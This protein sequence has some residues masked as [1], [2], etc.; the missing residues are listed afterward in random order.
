MSSRVYKHSP[1][2]IFCFVSTTTILP[3]I[4]HNKILLLIY[5]LQ[6][7]STFCLC[8]VMFSLIFV[9]IPLF[10]FSTGISY[11]LALSPF[12]TMY[13]TPTSFLFISLMY[14][15]CKIIS[16]CSIIFSFMRTSPVIGI[17]NEIV[18]SA[19][20]YSFTINLPYGYNVT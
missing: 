13:S 8:I 17:A 16:F 19:I 7:F 4:T 20:F 1:D 5:I 11:L 18:F 9:Y 2:S 10:S 14:F 12:I 6:L 15:G 3:D